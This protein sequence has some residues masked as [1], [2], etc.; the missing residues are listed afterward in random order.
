MVEEDSAFTPLL[1]K[2]GKINKNEHVIIQTSNAVHD[3]LFY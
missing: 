3:I 2:E 1:Y